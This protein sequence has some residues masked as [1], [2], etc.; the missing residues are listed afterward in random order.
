[1]I[2]IACDGSPQARQ[3]T[4]EAPQSISLLGA[5]YRLPFLMVDILAAPGLIS[6]NRLDVAARIG[7]DPDIPPSGRYYKA[8][9]PLRFPFTDGVRLSSDKLP[10]PS[11][12]QPQDWKGL[13]LGPAKLTSS[14]DTGTEH[15]HK[16]N[17]SAGSSVKRVRLCAMVRRISSRRKRG[18]AAIFFIVELQ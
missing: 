7:A 8:T 12:R 11:P 13:D 4:N 10:H 2:E 16:R 6:S 3:G 1:M 9:D 17:A 5:A 15:D 14:G 18:R